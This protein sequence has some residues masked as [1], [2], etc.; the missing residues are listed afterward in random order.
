MAL[1]KYAYNNNY[2]Y[3][4]LL[5]FNFKPRFYCGGKTAENRGLN[6]ISVKGVLLE[7]TQQ[8]IS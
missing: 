6:L 7:F 5:R 4:P 1:Y 8:Q 2:Y 3:F